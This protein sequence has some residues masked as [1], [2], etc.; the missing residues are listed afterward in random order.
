MSSPSLFLFFFLNDYFTE[1]FASKKHLI[2]LFLSFSSLHSHYFVIVVTL[3]FERVL[4]E[5]HVVKQA[6]NLN[7]AAGKL[8]QL[9]Q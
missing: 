2:V 5:Q 8:L 3:W 6:R 7:S 4:S 9:Q 1:S